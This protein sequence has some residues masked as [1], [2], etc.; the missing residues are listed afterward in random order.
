[1]KDTN[2]PI[3]T[4][5]ESLSLNSN[6]RHN[7]LEQGNYLICSCGKKKLKLDAIENGILKGKKSNGI[8]YTV[9]SDRHRYFFPDE[10][11]T[12]IGKFNNKQH[13][14][15]F[16]TLLHTG[17]R[18][19]E[20]L[21]LKPNNFNIERGTVT[22]EVVKQRKAKRQFF[23]IGKTRTF[24]VSP[25]YIKEVKAYILKNN[26]KGNEYLF[27]D[28]PSLPAN[29][30]NLNNLEKK[31]YYQKKVVAYSQLFRNKVKTSGIKDWKSF[32]LHNIRKT[33]GNW[34]RI[35][36]IK[37]DELCFRLGHDYNT[38]LIHYGSAMIFTPQERMK[39]MNILG[40]VR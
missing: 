35:Y 7:Y 10:W 5:K 3:E 34:M 9:R 31:K 25:K 37:T 38:Y 18:I 40:E 2:S 32:S 29:Y 1:M 20:A 36:D 19:M 6:H 12:F 4:P 15:L 17:A 8:D 14:L 16:L 22:F 39:I 11:Q 33:Y 28:N 13:Y 24:F 26:L 27:L 30:D 23:A 21:H